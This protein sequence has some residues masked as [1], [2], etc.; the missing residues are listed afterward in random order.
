L[1]GPDSTRG[2]EPITV[3]AKVFPRYIN[4]CHARI[5]QAAAMTPEEFTMMA[6]KKLSEIQ[7][8]MAAILVRLPGRSPREWLQ[9]EMQS[10]R[11]DQ[12]RDIQTLEALCAALES[13]TGKAW[14]L[15]RRGRAA[16][17]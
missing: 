6:K 2:G 9:K 5:D 10:A 13:E 14:R 12:K 3:A 4:P 16:R 8:E 17:R 15:K 7:A 1:A 11:G